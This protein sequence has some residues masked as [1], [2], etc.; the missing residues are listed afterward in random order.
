VEKESSL[1]E[2]RNSKNQ[3]K[4]RVPCWSTGTVKTSEKRGFL[5]GV[6]EQ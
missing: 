2:Y 6:R 5:V 1:L 4:K 3:W